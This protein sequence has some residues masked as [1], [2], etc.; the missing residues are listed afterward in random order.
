MDVADYP[1]PIALIP[2]GTASNAS[3]DS[4]AKAAAICVRY[5]D[6]PRYE[7]VAVIYY[8]G[9]TEN[10]ISVKASSNKEIDRVR[11]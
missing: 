3:E 2:Y 6:A 9:E 8:R 10:T 5:S 4:I 1:G 11:I 7:E